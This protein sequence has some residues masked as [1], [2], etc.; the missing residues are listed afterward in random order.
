MPRLFHKGE[1]YYELSPTTLLETEFEILLVQNAEIVRPD[2]RIVPFKRT[3]YDGEE[4]ARADLAIISEDY[5]E[6]VVVE[7]EMI[8]HSLHGHVIPQV[9]TLRGAAYGSED[10]DYLATKDE[11]LDREKLG[12][13]MKGL[14]P[15]V[16][17]IVNKP[18][19]EWK[20]ELRRYGIQMM[21]FEIFRSTKNRY[22][23]SVDGELP[24]LEQDIVTHL[25]CDPLLPRFVTVASPAA[26]EFAHGDKVNIF[27]DDQLTEWERID[28][29]NNCYIAPV[30]KMP[31]SRGRKY[32]LAK[33]GSQEYLIRPL[34]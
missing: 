2:S 7:V 32:V 26:L 16:L 4:S 33:V 25:E 15:E 27:I 17:V 3:V 5:R 19:D 20:R 24:H 30:G 31:L 29:R 1:W 10:A 12:A 8:R 18:D 9:R 6:W 14:P 21:V 34:G 28:I 22:I 11:A 13:M 23:F